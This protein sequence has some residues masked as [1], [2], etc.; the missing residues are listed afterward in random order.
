M[1]FSRV[2]I[3]IGNPE[4]PEMMD[5]G[6]EYDPEHPEMNNG[7]N[8]A[9]EHPDMI[10]DPYAPPIVPKE[11]ELRWYY[12]PFNIIDDIRH[13]ETDNL[14][15]D[16]VRQDPFDMDYRIIDPLLVF[17]LYKTVEFLIGKIRQGI[18][19]LYLASKTIDEILFEGKVCP[20]IFGGIIDT[21]LRQQIYTDIWDRYKAGQLENQS[22][23]QLELD[24]P[25]N[26]IGFVRKYYLRE[27]NPSIGN[28]IREIL[29]REF[30]RQVIHQSYPDIN[31]VFMEM[32]VEREWKKFTEYEYIQIT[33][34][35][36][37]L[38]FNN[39][40]KLSIIDDIRLK[41]TE[42]QRKYPA[43]L[44]HAS[45]YIPRINM[46][47]TTVDISGLLNLPIGIQIDGYVFQ[48]LYQWIYFSLFRKY[49]HISKKEAHSFIDDVN[50]QQRL[51]TIVQS[52]RQQAM[53]DAMRVKFRL[54]PQ[55]QELLFYLES[56]NQIIRF[57]KEPDL[58]LFWKRIV[59]EDVDAFSQRLMEFI[60]NSIPPSNHHLEKCIFLFSFFN[61]F[62]RSM[63]IFQTINGTHLN[64][65]TFDLFIE[66]FYPSLQILPS[67]TQDV[68]T[69]AFKTL[70]S[71]SRVRFIPKAWTIL[72]SYMEQFLSPDFIPSILFQQAKEMMRIEDRLMASI[73]VL[74]GIVRCLYEPENDDISN[75]DLYHIVKIISGRNDIAPWED[76]CRDI[77]MD[78]IIDPDPPGY[79]D[80]PTEIRD[81]DLI[82]KKKKPKKEQVVLHY[83]FIHPLLQPHMDRIKNMLGRTAIFDDVVSRITFAI[84]SLFKN[85]TNPR[86]LHFFLQNE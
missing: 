65:T 57:Q 28:N 68:P 73:D 55:I 54:Y 37:N 85:T 34:R 15:M 32:T 31:I 63:R 49:G 67:P 10:Y 47:D 8:E 16:A 45:H 30:L 70:F 46:E 51:D 69:P 84:A 43:E 78:R 2:G 56:T 59:T 83:T 61:E 13:G 18:D 75:D 44:T 60:V 24:Y 14:I 33:D 35:L 29:F 76:P 19:I 72:N 79:R 40:F 48:T 38:F 3:N 52:Q 77:V 74:I 64:Q 22:L 36:F 6:E 71:L 26:L 41:A 21:H 66:C 23:I 27:I 4:H 20:A 17:K 5:Y 1:S 39:R 58:M 25:G 7:N 86:R 50:L 82:R 62:F 9:E 42:T 80:L 11:K 53:L 12:A 81:H